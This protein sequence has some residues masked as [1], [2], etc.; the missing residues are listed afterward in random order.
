VLISDIFGVRNVGAIM[1]TITAGWALGAAIGPAAAGLAFDFTGQY[2][3]SFVFAAVGMIIST[4]LVIML[5][6]GKAYGLKQ[7]EK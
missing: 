6:T 7:E 5:R 3:V 2:T 1:G 4:I